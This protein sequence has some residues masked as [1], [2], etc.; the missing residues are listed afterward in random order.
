MTVDTAY[1]DCIIVVWSMCSVTGRSLEGHCMSTVRLL[2]D[3]YVLLCGH[4]VITVQLLYVRL[5]AFGG[6]VSTSGT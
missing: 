6:Q 1:G 5:G 2:Y 3:H 4:C